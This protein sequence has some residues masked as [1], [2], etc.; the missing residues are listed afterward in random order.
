MRRAL[1]AT[2]SATDERAFMHQRTVFSVSSA[3]VGVCLT[4]IALI[5]VYERLSMARAVS[6]VL[7]AVDA[8]VFLIGAL[9]S[10]FALHA[11]VRGQRSSVHVLA[12]VAVL[13]G[14]LLMTLVCA[15]LVLTMV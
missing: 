10:F 13:L 11:L 8:L 3:M 12:D 1:P 4:A 2:D 15:L 14:L 9:L 5:M 7:L 6:R